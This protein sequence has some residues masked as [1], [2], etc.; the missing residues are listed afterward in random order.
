[1]F[2]NALFFFFKSKKQ[3]NFGYFQSEKPDPEIAYEPN[4]DIHYKSLLF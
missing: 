3:T 4:I 1:M 2:I